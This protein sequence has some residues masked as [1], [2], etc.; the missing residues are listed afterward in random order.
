MSKFGLP[1]AFF[2]KSD[3]YKFSARDIYAVYRKRCLHFFFLQYK[4]HS[5]VTKRGTVFSLAL[6]SLYAVG[7]FTHLKYFYY[8][9]C[10]IEMVK[11]P[12]ETLKRKFDSIW[13]SIFCEIDVDMTSMCWENT[14]RTKY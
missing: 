7:L 6:K 9:V 10:C 14:L 11:T 2:G 5:D 4:R 13:T 1:C 3:S 8:Y 12:I